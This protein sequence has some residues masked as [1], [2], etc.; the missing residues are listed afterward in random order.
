MTRGH[1]EL[2]REIE[3]MPFLQECAQPTEVTA[4]PSEMKMKVRHGD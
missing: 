3:G 4:L 2:P 1:F